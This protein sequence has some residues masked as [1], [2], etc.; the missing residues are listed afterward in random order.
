MTYTN[1]IASLDNMNY[2]G[3]KGQPI[4]RVEYRADITVITNTRTYVRT[5]FHKEHL[6][7]MRN[8]QNI[9]NSIMHTE[10]SK[11]N[12]GIKR[13]YY[14]PDEIDEPELLEVHIIE[15]DRNGNVKEV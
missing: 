12:N 8:E 10:W 5:V 6:G 4:K 14:M 13:G 3:K 1:I 11:Y 15:T 2:V 7:L 9:I